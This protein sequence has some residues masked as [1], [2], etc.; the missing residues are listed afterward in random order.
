MAATALDVFDCPLQGV[1]L[2]EASAGTG[3]TWNICGLYLRLLV[4]QQRAVRDILVVT[5]TN[6][7]TAELRERI[8]GRCAEVLAMLEGRAAESKDPFARDFLASLARKG[9]GADRV[10][11]ALTVAVRTF[12]E[13]SIFTIHGFCKRALGDAPFASAMPLAM[14]LLDDETELVEQ[15]ARDFWRR[16]VASAEA[17]AQLAAYVGSRDE[18]GAWARVLAKRVAKPL[19][20]FR[21]PEPAAAALDTSLFAGLH[22]QARALWQAD[23]AAIVA[24]VTD[25]IGS[26]NGTIFRGGTDAVL[27]SAREWDQALAL[28][29]FAFPLPRA[30]RKPRLTTDKLRPKKGQ[31]PCRE[32]AFF[33]VA[34]RYLQ[35]RSELAEAAERARLGLLRQL[36]EQGPAHLQRLKRESRV[37]AFTDMLAN[38]H[39]R[40]QAGEGADALARALRQRFPAAL[41]DEFQD[42]DPL[43]FGI[44]TRIYGSE[45]PLFLVGDPKQAIYS[46][47]GADLHTYLQAKPRAAAEYTLAENQR[48]TPQVIEALNALF[49]QRADPFMLAELRYHPVRAGAKPR[50]PFADPAARGALHLLALPGFDAA[51]DVVS[52]ARAKDIALATSARE[53]AR[54]L[55]GGVQHDRGALRAGDIAVLVRTRREGSAMRQALAAAGVAS[56][57]MADA[58][59]F[60][61]RDAEELECL[62]SAIAQPGRETLL[63]A[64]LATELLGLTA[65]RIDS[66]STQ[67]AESAGWMARFAAYR[68]DW[69][70]RGV[71]PML[72]AAAQDLR[73]TEGL[74]ARPD[75]ERRMT[76]LRHLEELLHAA[77]ESH[78]TPESL[79]HWLQQQRLHGQAGEGAQ[80]RLESDRNLVQIVTIHKCKGLEY[81]VVFC[82]TLW[83]GS[84]GAGGK[85][86]WREYHDGDAMVVDLRIL[87]PAEE[88]RV[89][90]IV[91]LEQ[92]AERL[93]LIYVALTRAVHRCYLVVGPYRHGKSAGACR[94]SRANPLHWLFAQDGVPQ[95]WPEAPAPWDALAGSMRRYAVDNA[96]VVALQAAADIPAA[97]LAAPASAA[98]DIA[99]LPAPRGI[100]FGWQTGS[101]SGLAHGASH[102]LAAAD[103]DARAQAA[104][105]DAWTVPAGLPDDDFLR[106]PR[107]ARAGELV[108][109]VFEKL[110]FPRADAGVPVI[111]GVLQRMAPSPAPAQPVLLRMLQGM[112]RQVLA[113]PLHGGFTLASLHAADR[114]AELEF[115]MSSPSLRAQ[116][117]A[118]AMQAHGYPVPFLAAE[119][120]Q[121]YLRGFVDLVYRHGGRYFVLDWKTNHLGYAREGYGRDGL[122]HAMAAQGYHL[123]SLLYTV[124]LHRWLRTRLPGYAYDTHVGGVRY[125]FVRGMRD[126]WTDGQGAPLGVYADHPPRA[127]VEALDAAIGHAKDKA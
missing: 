122:A 52:K 37:L 7:A 97:R 6:A 108:H 57:E 55:S 74:L 113:T 12:D 51:G 33:A 101:Y 124:A 65:D 80:V 48:S 58:S 93:R 116:D 85:D 119:R 1:R 22:R 107:G 126:G 44:F 94:E 32:H 79:L 4:E 125:L 29:E 76:N 16:H 18:P 64:A 42:T 61:S 70:R 60:D 3:K 59:V 106:F 39:E 25:N 66:L 105:G 75:G 28:P 88:A 63:R 47:R 91:G 17:D 38:L 98:G 110:D 62:L 120:L 26:L 53:I 77:S 40:L 92:A 81:P 19:A 73:I 112:V 31:P 8:R 121:G 84:P 23:R 68:A 78:G 2:V 118:A 15:V 83:D 123:Q 20:Q 82:P 67:E 72:R 34:T 56:I 86:P 114:V 100:P 30:G 109:A 27:E 54:L 45:G 96:K 5:F 9:I 99:A 90:G 117:I 10:R 13:A 50:K 21:W 43:Q 11:Q 69:P 127:L 41:I 46:F 102:E 104:R 95:A 24:C 71:A 49:M 89:E 111:Q 103:R 14:D 36:A 35:A 115:S 87:E